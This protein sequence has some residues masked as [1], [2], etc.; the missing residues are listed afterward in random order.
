MQI[1]DKAAKAFQSA[2]SGNFAAAFFRLWLGRCTFFAIAFSVVGLYGWLVLNRDL[3]SF[4]LFAGSIQALLLAHSYKED[5]AQKQ[6]QDQ[7]QVVE[8]NVQNQK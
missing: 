3:T 1:P 7:Q 2:I 6:Q 4:A 8:V 5:V